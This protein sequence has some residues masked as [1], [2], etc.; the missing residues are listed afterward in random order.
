MRAQR[1]P[2][3]S[4]SQR[5]ERVG[6]LVELV[7]GLQRAAEITA[8]H[9]DT[10]NKWRRPGAKLPLD[11]MLRLCEAAGRTLDW[12]ATGHDTRPDLRAGEG[13]VTPARVIKL[14]DQRI[15][16]HLRGEAG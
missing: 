4:D 3:A 5:H 10:V 6:Q 7:G 8:A 13:V 14:I 11:G 15:A 1:L 2:A 12:L 9:P 16:R